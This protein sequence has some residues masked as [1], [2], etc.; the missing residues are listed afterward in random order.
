MTHYDTL[1]IQKDATAAEIK[2][3]YRRMSMKHHPDRDT[4][5]EET[6]KKVSEAYEVLSDPQE[7]G[8]YDNPP[9]R[10]GAHGLGGFQ[11][12]FEDMMRQQSNF[13][14]PNSDEIFDVQ[15]LAKDA[16]YGKDL[17]VS[18][19]NTSYTISIPPGTRS[20]VKFRLAGQGQQR[21]SS[22]PPGDIILRGRVT[23]PAEI[24]VHQNDIYQRVEVS[25]IDCMI[26]GSV[27]ILHLNG[28]KINV[29][30]PAGSQNNAQ[31]RLS[32]LGMPN[33]QYPGKFGNL[34]LV[35]LIK[36][37]QISD[38]KHIDMLNTINDE[39]KKEK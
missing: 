9:L 6:F 22:L 29:K 2:K 3:A 30:I 11:A 35:L 16:Y 32:N 7:R 27:E 38:E 18:I 25:P 1:G 33:P 23:Y 39:L 26:G 17:I 14:M 13:Q 12:H 8:N 5:D 24:E 21:D 15:I 4:G 31:L 34:F 37:P 28:K 20:G 36:I 19:R 10:Q